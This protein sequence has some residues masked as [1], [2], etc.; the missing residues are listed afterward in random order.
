VDYIDKITAAMIAKDY[1]NFGDYLN[2]LTP[3]EQQH[4]QREDPGP[5]PED[6]QGTD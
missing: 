6:I 5:T 1:Q 4:L 3:S 2:S